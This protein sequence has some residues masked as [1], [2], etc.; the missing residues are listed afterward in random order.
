ML[1]L[2]LY[3][4]SW[5]ASLHF[6]FVLVQVKLHVNSLSLCLLSLVLQASWLIICLSFLIINSLLDDGMVCLAN[7]HM[8][9]P[10]SFSFFFFL[11]T[12]NQ[13]IRSSDLNLTKRGKYKTYD[14]LIFDFEYKFFYFSL[15]ITRIFLS[16]LKE[17][18]TTGRIY[19]TGKKQMPIGLKVG[20]ALESLFCLFPFRFSLFGFYLLPLVIKSSCW[21]MQKS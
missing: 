13:G 3:A 20:Q 12:N 11:T 14:R 10:F 6:F 21:I 4:T 9:I 8:S 19:D 1:L 5:Y 16:F 17:I 7:S 2:I 15:N 18:G